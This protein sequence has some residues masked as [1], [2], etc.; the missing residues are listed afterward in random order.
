MW[1]EIGRLSS[2]SQN[3]EADGFI[4]REAIRFARLIGAARPVGLDIVEIAPMY[5]PSGA[6]PRLACNIILETIAAYAD[7][8]AS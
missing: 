8:E 4:S 6:T 5:E 1:H 3:P 7:Q 2:L